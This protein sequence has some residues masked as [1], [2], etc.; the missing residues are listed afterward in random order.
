MQEIADYR[1][2][3]PVV[4]DKAIQEFCLRLSSMTFAGRIATEFCTW[5]KK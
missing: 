1:Y 4:E 3:S 2:S 5:M